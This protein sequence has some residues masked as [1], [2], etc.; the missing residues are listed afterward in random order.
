MPLALM[1]ASDLSV[2]RLELPEILAQASAFA[3]FDPGRAHVCALRPTTDHA[4]ARARLTATAQARWLLGEAPGFSVGGAQDV[5]AA[6]AAASRGSRLSPTDL[7]AVSAQLRAV[8]LTRR[9]VE[10][11]RAD[12]PA[13]WRIVAPLADHPELGSRID[14]TFDEQGRVADAA[15]PELQSLRRQLRQATAAVHAIMQQQLRSPAAR[16]VLQE[17]LI[18]ERSG[19]QVVPVKQ[20]H[21]G[22][23]PGIVHDTSASGATVYMEPLAA[24]PA[25]NRVRELEAAERHEIDRILRALS[26]EVGDVARRHRGGGR[27]PGRA[28]RP[29]GA[30]ALRGCPRGRGTRH[31][32]GR[33]VPA[34]GSAASLAGGRGRA[35]RHRDPVRRVAGHRD[36]RP[37]HRRQD[38]VAQDGWDCCT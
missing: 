31:R 7:Q 9:T 25:N 37:Q 24:V 26:A 38:G 27:R 12:T 21:Q 18:T 30:G 10:T 5:R 19:R 13:L 2:D 29:A 17:A 33:G 36:H 35:H 14:A 4:E 16:G 32:A 3:G 22:S 11:H 28:R 6:A 34:E 8:R 15:S 1:L 20:E 23:F